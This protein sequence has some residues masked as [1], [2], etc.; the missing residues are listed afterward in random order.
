ML[1]ACASSGVD[2]FSMTQTFAHHEHH[3][4]RQVRTSRNDSSLASGYPCG[5][6]RRGIPKSGPNWY[7]R[8]WMDRL[9]VTQA[10]MSR[11]TGW[12]KASASQIYNGKQDYNPNIVREAADALMVEQ[13]EL[14][15]PYDRAMAIRRIQVTAKQIA[16]HSVVS[17]DKT[18]T[19]G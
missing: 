4:K 15:M 8:E 19:D 7:I 9:N 10:E 14:L 11:R 2:G 1:A 5:M 16:S 18:G 6:T 12:S 17:P 3:C 13:W